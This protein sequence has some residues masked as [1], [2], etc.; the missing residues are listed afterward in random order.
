MP[1]RSRSA[2]RS[3]GAAA[4]ERTAPGRVSTH[5]SRHQPLL[6]SGGSEIVRVV[7]ARTSS[8]GGEPARNLAREVSSLQVRLLDR[9]QEELRDDDV[10]TYANAARELAEAFGSV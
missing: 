10:E 4:S 9:L 3:P 8:R 7:E 2:R 5:F 6:A 1:T